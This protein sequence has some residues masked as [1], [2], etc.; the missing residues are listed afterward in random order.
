MRKVFVFVVCF[1]MVLLFSVALAVR[2]EQID[3]SAGQ[4][5]NAFLNIGVGTRAV[6]MGEA[7]TGIADDISSLYWNP[8]GLSKVRNFQALLM[9]NQWFQNVLYEYGA[10][11]VPLAKGT[12]AGSLAYVNYGS[13]ERINEFGQEE[14]NFVV[15]DVAISLGYGMELF[16][17]FAVGIG[18]KTPFCQDD[19]NKLTL[20][21]A[22]DIGLLYGIP[23]LDGLNIGINLMNVGNKN[24]PSRLKLGLGLVNVFEGLK[25]GWDIGTGFYA[26]EV[27]MNVGAEYEISGI[28]VPRLGYK[29]STEERKV[30]SSGLAGLTLGVGLRLVISGEALHL[31][32]AYVPYGDIGAAHRMG[33]LVEFGV[34]SS[35][36][37]KVVKKPKPAAKKKSPI[38]GPPGALRVERVGRRARLSWAGSPSPESYGYNVYMKRGKKGKYEKINPEV[39]KGN[40]YLINTLLKKEKYY[41]M[42]KTVDRRGRRESRGAIVQKVAKKRYA[43]QKSSILQ[44]PRQVSVKR[45]GR[46]ASLNWESSS[47]AKSYGYNVYMKRGKKGKYSKINPKLI[48]G[49]AYLINTLLKKEKYHFMV[50]TVDRRGRES[51][52]ATVKRVAKKRYAKQKST[53]LQPPRQVSVKQI[54]SKVK[55]RWV[56]SR[57][58]KR[59]GYNVYMKKGQRGKYIKLNTRLI[60]AN[61]Y[62][63]GKLSRKRAYYFIVKT[64]DQ[65]GRKSRGTAPKKAY[66]Q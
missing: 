37:A 8:A 32:Y 24:Q 57:S 15:R 23:A 46:K 41:F 29:Y 26:E 45:T 44:P 38:L 4:S 5:G 10:F 48:K 6:G 9:N 53:V 3:Y 49:N 17:Q 55:L 12:V 52:G 25:I 11:G 42:V 47:S 58:S 28:L 59:Y 62:V 63:T 7:F 60:K 21:L 2:A 30:S 66:I 31:N 19:E 43:K 51:R 50:K 64:L 1:W 56:S 20:S 35:H 39:I 18:I 33:M 40:A 22:G 34:D 61:S 14:G 13:M 27:E 65:P 16:Q 54:G 36:A